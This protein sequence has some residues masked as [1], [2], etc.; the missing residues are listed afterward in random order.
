ML[1]KPSY[2]TKELYDLVI[3]SVKGNYLDARPLPEPPFL[4]IGCLG[5]DGIKEMQLW[6]KLLLNSQ[7]LAMPIVLGLTHWKTEEL[8]EVENLFNHRQ[9]ENIVILKG[10]W[11][12]C[13]DEAN[14]GRGFC[15]IIQSEQVARLVM[16]GPATEE[17]FD[18]LI[19]E[20]I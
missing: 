19:A 2:K 15:A 16:V 17:A 12:K 6:N 1:W 10:D 5:S 3:P 9:L 11:Q 13:L 8:K 14:P 20:I 18:K 4:L 7:K